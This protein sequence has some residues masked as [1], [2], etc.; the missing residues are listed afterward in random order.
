MFNKRR[1]LSLRKQL[2]FIKYICVLNFIVF[3]IVNFDLSALKQP[4]PTFKQHKKQL[5]VCIIAAATVFLMLYVLEPFNI[6]LLDAK[7][8]TNYAL[9]YSGITLVICV[10]LTVVIPWVFPNFFHEA[11]WTVIKEVCYI[12]LILI[13][14]SVVNLIA[15][16]IFDATPLNLITFLISVSYTLPLAAF[17]VTFS[18]LTKQKWLKDKYRNEAILWNTILQEYQ[19]KN[20]PAREDA[21]SEDATRTTSNLNKAPTIKLKT[22]FI[23][24]TGTGIGEAVE[25]EVNNFLF[26]SSADNYI[27][28]HYMAE[29]AVKTTILRNTLKNT[30]DKIKH[31]NAIARCNRSYIV[32]L[33]KVE[34]IIGDAQGLKLL[35]KNVNE[36]IL[37]GKSYLSTVKNLLQDIK[38]LK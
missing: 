11:K 9:L 4:F 22:D 10:L 36:P 23:T 7:T 27:T 20:I 17:P 31:L 32:N 16:N 2:S 15:H 18:I 28:V 30:A 25:I 6:N 14:I 3:Q 34:R 35:I 38:P 29:Q 12:C 8:K 21:V 5:L 24:L 19:T 26:I 37:V 33:N 13:V 1:H